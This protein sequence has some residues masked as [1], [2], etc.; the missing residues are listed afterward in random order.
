MPSKPQWQRPIEEVMP[1]KSSVKAAWTMFEMRR[2][3]A[4]DAA[5]VQRR[6]AAAIPADAKSPRSRRK[7]SQ[8]MPAVAAGKAR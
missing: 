6:R 8:N 2:G 7:R 4:S 3:L 5:I 1:P